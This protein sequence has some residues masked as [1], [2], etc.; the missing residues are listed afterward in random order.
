MPSDWFAVRKVLDALSSL[1]VTS[2]YVFNGDCL[3]CDGKP[4]GWITADSFYLKN[5]WKQI[6]QTVGLPL[7][8]TDCKPRPSFIIREDQYDEPWFPEVV[9]ATADALP[10]KE[11]RFRTMR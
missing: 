5:T 11:K 8:D 2:R 6:P 3:C 9:Q 10:S 1:D 4:V 7:E